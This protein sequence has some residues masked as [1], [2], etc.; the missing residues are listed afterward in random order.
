MSDGLGGLNASRSSIYFTNNYSN[1][2]LS[3]EKEELKRKVKDLNRVVK[4][5]SKELDLDIFDKDLRDNIESIIEDCF[6]DNVKDHESYINSLNKSIKDCESDIDKIKGLG[7]VAGKELIESYR[8]FK[9][10]LAIAK[11]IKEKELK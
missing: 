10:E 6:N 2:S 4:A 9:K 1:M 8:G 7:G 11:N 5:L 3:D